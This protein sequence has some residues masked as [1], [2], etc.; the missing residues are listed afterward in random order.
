MNNTFIV[1]KREINSAFKNRIFIGML[2]ITPALIAALCSI[3]S[4]K[5]ADMLFNSGYIYIFLIYMSITLFSIRVMKG[6][7]EEKTNRLSEILLSSVKSHEL[8]GGKILGIGLTGIMQILTWAIL[9]FVFIFLFN[10]N[11]PEMQHTING[12]LLSVSFIYFILYFIGGYLL[13]SAIFAM[14]AAS[15]S[16]ETETQQ[17]NLLVTMLL[18]IALVSNESIMKMPNGKLALWLS[19]LPF[20]SPIT[21]ISRIFSGEVA[22]WQIALSLFFLFITTV[23]VSVLSGKVYRNKIL[24]QGRSFNLYKFIGFSK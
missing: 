19:E 6:V 22:F 15:A 21:M 5:Y 10:I 17:F 24:T 2:F 14:V 11:W 23:I 13:Y 1:A 8:L 18:F 3:G 20:T 12:N 7:S 16:A 9:V 4:V